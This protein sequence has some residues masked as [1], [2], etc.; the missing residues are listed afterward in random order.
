MPVTIGI[1]INPGRLPRGS[2]RSF[3]YDTLS[4]QY[5]RF[6]E[7]EILPEVAQEFNLRAEAAGRAICGIS[8]GGLCAFTVAWERPAL[9]SKVL[10]HQGTPD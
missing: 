10:S 9:F 7:K 8:S 2:N 4:D 1:F 6:L 5:V 3:G